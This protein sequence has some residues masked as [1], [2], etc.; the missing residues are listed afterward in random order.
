MIPG[1][2]LKGILM[3]WLKA[4][5]VVAMVTWFAG[6]FYLPR[7]YV[8]HAGATDATSIARFEIMERRLFLITTIGASLTIIF[9]LAMIVEMPLYLS[10]SWLRVKL[11]LVLLLVAYHGY[12]FKIIR[13]FVRRRNSRSARWYRVFNELPTLLLIGIVILAVV[14]PAIL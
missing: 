5:H 4:L 14:K 11:V 7:L 13:D 6:L 8:Y 12:C 10:F 2:T 1:Q 3:L 9:G